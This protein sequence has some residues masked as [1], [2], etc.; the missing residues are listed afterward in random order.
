MAGKKLEIMECVKKNIIYATLSQ[1]RC[2]L[3]MAF[4]YKLKEILLF[5]GLGANGNLLND[6]WEF[7]K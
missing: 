1:P 4:D 7:C 6:T 2:A 3:A 5:G